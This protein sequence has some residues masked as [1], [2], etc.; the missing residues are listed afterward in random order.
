M[1][2][3]TD[4]ITLDDMIFQLKYVISSNLKQLNLQDAIFFAEKSYVMNQK[5]NEI[6]T[7]FSWSHKEQFL[8]FDSK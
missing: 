2:S 4:A 3:N 7:Q 5:R 6:S 1:L 8:F